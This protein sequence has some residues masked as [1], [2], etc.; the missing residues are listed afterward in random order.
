MDVVTSVRIT[1]LFL[2]EI[3]FVTS[4]KHLLANAASEKERFR[5]DR[6]LSQ[7]GHASSRLLPSESIRR[8][9]NKDMGI[10]SQILLPLKNDQEETNFNH[11]AVRSLRKNRLSN[12]LSTSSNVQRTLNITHSELLNANNLNE[13]VPLFKNPHSNNLLHH[14]NHR[15]HLH[16]KIFYE[17]QVQSRDQI[18][19]GSLNHSRVYLQLFKNWNIS[20]CHFARSR[21]RHYPNHGCL[22]NCP[23]YQVPCCWLQNQHRRAK[24]RNSKQK[25]KRHAEKRTFT[26]LEA[27]KKDLAKNLGIQP[28]QETRHHSRRIPQSHDTNRLSKWDVGD[29]VIMPSD[30]VDGR[31]PL[32]KFVYPGIHIRK[33]GKYLCIYENGSIIPVGELLQ[34]DLHCKYIP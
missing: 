22:T 18:L 25:S 31:K 29:T 5:S 32:K 1:L 19:C 3:Y 23:A 9:I 8:S 34:L 6:G 13:Q 28:T 4:R 17:K 2:L 15:K 16:Q 33:G 21:L 30:S 14:N 11:R 27:F 24:N 20:S 10:I 7:S 12:S 26:S